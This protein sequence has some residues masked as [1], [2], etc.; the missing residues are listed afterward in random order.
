MNRSP[1]VVVSKTRRV[2]KAAAAGGSVPTVSR[3][4]RDRNGG[5]DAGHSPPDSTAAWRAFAHPTPA[6]RRLECCHGLQ[7]GRADLGLVPG[8]FPR[9]HVGAA[10]MRTVSVSRQATHS[11]DR[12]DPEECMMR[13]P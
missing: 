6:D 1:F 9:Y 5:H 4:T 8:L 13:C 12:L 10:L 7:Q 11:T 3:E 2:G